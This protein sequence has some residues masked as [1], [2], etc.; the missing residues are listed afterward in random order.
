[1]KKTKWGLILGWHFTQGD[2]D[3]KSLKQHLGFL[4][5][6]AAELLSHKDLVPWKMTPH[7]LKTEKGTHFSLISLLYIST[8]YTQ[9]ELR[10][11]LKK[12]KE[13]IPSDVITVSH[14][15]PHRQQS[16]GEKENRH[17]NDFFENY[18]GSVT[19]G[20]VWYIQCSIVDYTC[21][22]IL[23]QLPVNH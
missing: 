17:L 18:L 1:M 20:A 23:T 16:H 22:A 10:P 9:N 13:I 7:P 19:H 4:W 3:H 14:P 12:C 11:E 6:P 2:L 21:G 8:K 5:G 15:P